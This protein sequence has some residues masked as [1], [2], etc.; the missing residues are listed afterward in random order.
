MSELQ[1]KLSLRMKLKYLTGKL[2]MNPPSMK[3]REYVLQF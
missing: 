2:S 1:E 3:N